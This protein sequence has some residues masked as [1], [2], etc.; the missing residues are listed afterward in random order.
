MRKEYEDVMARMQNA[1]KYAKFEFHN[2]IN[3]RTTDFLEFYSGASKSDRI[4]ILNAMSK[5]VAYLWNQ[6]FPFGAL[7]VHIVSLNVESHFV[8]GEDAEY[9]RQQTDILIKEAYDA[10]KISN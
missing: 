5:N 1:N 8:H 9:V 6:N 3:H 2:E 4:K 7:G 10:F